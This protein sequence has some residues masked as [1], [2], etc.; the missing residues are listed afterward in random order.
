[1]AA[2]GSVLLPSVRLTAHCGRSSSCRHTH[3]L[4]IRKGRSGEDALF[5]LRAQTIHISLTSTVSRVHKMQRNIVLS[6]AAMYPAEPSLLL[7]QERCVSRG[8]AVSVYPLSTP[9]DL[10][11]A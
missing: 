6:P 7:K 4:A 10:W 1:M 9:W 5:L 3:I 8:L 2:P 11:P